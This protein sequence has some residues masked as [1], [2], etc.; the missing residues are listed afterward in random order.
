MSWHFLQG[1]EAV[2]SEAISWDG[3]AF[4]P[5]KSKTTLEGYCLPASATES[6]HAFRFGTTC[7]LSMELSGEAESMLSVVDSPARTSATPKGQGPK[8]SMAP[9]ADYGAKWLV[10]SAKFDPASLSWKTPQR[11]LFGGLIECSRIWPRF[12]LMLD[13]ECFPLEML[14]HDTSVKDYGY[15]PP[16]GTPIK[17]QRSRSAEFLSPAQN[18]FELCPKGFLPNPEWCEE[19]MGWPTAW[20]A[21]QPLATARFRQWLDSHGRCLGEAAANDG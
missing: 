2:S 11:S 19:L 9:A 4:V 10:S 8:E 18:P 21:L 1:R 17:S 3:A 15:G 16:I 13:G 12:G 6:C 5:S 20:T 14:E 7:E